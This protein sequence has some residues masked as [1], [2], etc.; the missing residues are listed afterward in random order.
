MSPTSTPTREATGAQDV[1]PVPDPDSGVGD[2]SVAL[3]II[4]L[5]SSSIIGEPPGM[6]SFC[7]EYYTP[8][9]PGR[10]AA[11]G[12]A[13]AATGSLR[14][15]VSDGVSPCHVWCPDYTAPPGS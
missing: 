9:P 3:C 6:S 11:R 7:T 13:A 12:P 2:V 10:V 4:N 15:G 14:P 1:F 5:T 8:S